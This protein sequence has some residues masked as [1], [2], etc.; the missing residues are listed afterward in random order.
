MGNI[1][2]RQLKQGRKFFAYTLLKSLGTG[3][4]MVI[5][6]G[7]AFI[8]SPETFGVYSLGKMVI[9]LFASI[10]IYS[11]LGPF[12][13]FANQE[14]A[15]SGK[16]NRSFSNQLIFTG[17]SVVLFLLVTLIFRNQLS[18][19]IGIGNQ[20][21]LWLCFAFVGVTF[22]FFLSYLFLALNNKRKD[23]LFN[24]LYGVISVLAVL[25]FFGIHN[26]TIKTLFS[27]YFIAMVLS[28]PFYIR[29][30]NFS[31][32]RPWKIEKKYFL[33][34]FAYARW[35]F[36]GAAAL[37][38]INWGDNIVLKSYTSIGD[39]GVYNFGYQIFKGIASLILIINAYYLP[40]VSQQIVGDRE[41][42]KKFL[43]NKRPKIFLLGAS[44][45]CMLLALLPIAINNIFPSSYHGAIPVIEILLLVAVLELY[46]IFYATVLTATKD[47]KFT[48][49]T[50]MFQVTLNIALDIILVPVFGI[51][52]AAI[53]T[54]IAYLARNIAYEVYFVV[55]YKDLSLI[56]VIHK[57]A[58]TPR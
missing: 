55:K 34:M 24:L 12:V 26:L 57:Y 19:F 32:L 28:L 49:M 2:M 22:K 8:I 42:V 7:L 17:T 37:Y 36:F 45:L 40:V 52:G 53:G 41:T 39:I 1:I 43:F 33:E 44:L 58:G 29:S 16:I 14:M 9:F 47:Y 11:S 25:Y 6:L 30:I 38:L 50:S 5:P 23:S 27:V 20:E 48:Q 15:K 46:N 54:A 21:L 3:L 4:E 51:L 31:L 13:V 18:A 35:Q 56:S 10:F